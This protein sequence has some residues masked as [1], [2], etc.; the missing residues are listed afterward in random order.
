MRQGKGRDSPPTPRCQTVVTASPFL[1][2]SS[3]GALI[4][5]G[6]GSDAD[7]IST[8]L[9]FHNFFRCMGC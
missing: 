4:V 5:A 3:P 9:F 7:R 1:G 8:S 6:G 2:L